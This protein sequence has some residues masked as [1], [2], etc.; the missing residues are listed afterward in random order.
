[1]KRLTYTAAFLLAGGLSTAH[2]ADLMQAW[3]NAQARDPEIAAARALYE[4]A[5]FRKEQA[6]ALWAPTI[7][8]TGA[9]G[10]G[11]AD[12]RTKG[13]EA[14][15][16]S[17]VTFKTN[18]NV[19][20]LTRASV[21]AQKAWINPEREAQSQQLELSAQLAE[22][23]WQLAQHALA[24]RTA[25][26]YFEVV[27]AE[28]TLQIL[29]QQQKAVQQAATEIK[30]RQ[31]VGDASV[32]DVQEANSRV[33][34]I[35]AHVL[36]QENDV[37]MKRLAYRQLVGQEPINLKGL[38]HTDSPPRNLADANT[39]VQRAKQQSPN[40]QMMRFQ[41]AIQEQEVK[42]VKSDQGLRAD[43]VAQAQM[44]RL[45]GQGMYGS[46]SN[47][48]TQ[49]LVGI[50]V[51]VPLSTGGM[52][53]AREREAL[54]QVDKLRFDQ[55]LTELQVEHNVRTAW[56]NISTA[57]ARLQA[58][59]QSDKASQARL[60][61]TRNAHRT[62]AR[63]TNEW[64]GAEHDAAQA[65]LALVQL[66]IQTVLDRLRLQAASGELGEAQLQEI[67]ALLK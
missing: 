27:G 31:A 35:R 5:A 20:T 45:M 56:Q 3:Q 60:A 59:I 2:S 37:A 62:G 4:Q 1:M 34:D 19:G 15:G 43:W 30:K 65:E 10:V 44:D 46:A 36:T 38:A 21:G 24:M 18:V 42:R 26:K 33:A 41:Q 53:E 22:K 8:V 52:V 32:M 13:A 47:Q 58:L 23:Q 48:T 28:Q 12:S 66:R 16:Y 17:D 14:L 39:W 50:Q 29:Q 61:A 54:K 40:L 57:Q 11:G 6:Q 67:N 25:Q 51:N 7:G 49:Y 63:T 55:E 9:L 64:L